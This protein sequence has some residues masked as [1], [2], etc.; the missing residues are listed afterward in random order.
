MRKYLEKHYDFQEATWRH[1]YRNHSFTIYFFVY[2]L[3]IIFEY[4]PVWDILGAE[5]TAVAETQN[6][7]V[8]SKQEKDDKQTN[9][10]ISDE[11]SVMKNN[12]V[13]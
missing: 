11:S 5:N 12:K 4:I 3:R 9:I 6:K 7:T 1:W 2:Y 13:R 8:F 10:I